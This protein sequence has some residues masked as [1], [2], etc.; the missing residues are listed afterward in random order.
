MQNFIINI[1]QENFELV[2]NEKIGCFII[3]QDLNDDFIISFIDMAKKS[4]KI[5]LISGNYAEINPEKYSSDGAILD[6]SKE[7]HPKKI[8][9]T[10][11]IKYPKALIGVVSRNRRHE[12]MLISECEPEFV[13]FKVWKDGFEKSAELVNWYNEL[14]L[15]QYAIWPV[16]GA[17]TS[18]LKTDFVIVDDVNFK[19]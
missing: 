2:K 19:N 12:A 8:I 14:F 4:G 16:D 1:T 5:C 15:I 6:L 13:I 11:K 10:F 9:K 7:E 18:V 3:S 17:D